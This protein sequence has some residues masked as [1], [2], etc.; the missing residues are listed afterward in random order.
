MAKARQA[1]A[2]NRLWKLGSLEPE[3]RTCSRSGEASRALQ[4]F[5]GL[6]GTCSRRE[7]Q[8]GA[9]QAGTD[10]AEEGARLESSNNILHDKVRYLTPYSVSLLLHAP[11]VFVD[12][13]GTQDTGRDNKAGATTTRTVARKE[14]W[15]TMNRPGRRELQGPLTVGKRT[16]EK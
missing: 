14:Q 6:A 1:K 10:A 4:H 2:V 12:R 16:R 15:T 8:D 9:H 7:A 11:Q 5:A 13:A 3:E